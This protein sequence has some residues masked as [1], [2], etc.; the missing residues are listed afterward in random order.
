[1]QFDG[2]DL[3]KEAAVEIIHASETSA[4]SGPG[5]VHLAEKAADEVVCAGAATT[6]IQQTG[7]KGLGQKA[8][9]LGEHGDDR[10]QNKAAGR[11]AILAAKDHGIES[12]SHA[13]RGLA[14]DRDPVVAKD[15]RKLARE[16]KVQRGMAGGQFADFDP[17]HRLLKLRVEIVNPQLVEI[18]EHNVG[19]AMRNEIE[20]V[21][22][23]LLIMLRELRPARFHFDEHSAGPNKV[24][25]LGALAWKTDA[26]LEGAAFRKGVG[27]VAKGFE[28]MEK[29]RL[30]F[31]FLVTLKFGGEFGELVKGAFLRIH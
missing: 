17:V 3:G 21:I 15:R 31:A 28:Q 12:V 13:L 7:E 25:I 1:M 9:V 19:G 2:F 10:L 27:V 8:D 30:R 23:C 18:A 4:A 14:C 29:E 16:K 24:G 5:F 22:E 20:P 26:I 11:G 6:F